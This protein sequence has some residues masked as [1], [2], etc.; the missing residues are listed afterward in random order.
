MI[1]VGTLS[2]LHSKQLGFD[3]NAVLRL[4]KAI[5]YIEANFRDE[6]HLD[7]LAR[8]AGISGRQLQRLFKLGTGDTPLVYLKNL[9]L[10]RAAETLRDPNNRITEAAFANGLNDSNNFSHQF[11][12]FFGV[13]PR[14]YRSEAGL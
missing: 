5:N 4:V 6:L 10:V 1:L 2:R 8:V 7:N 14:Q 9:R 12:K 3:T 11:Q 13:S